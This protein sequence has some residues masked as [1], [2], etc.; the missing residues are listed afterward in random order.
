MARQNN[1]EGCYACHDRGAFLVLQQVCLRSGRSVQGHR[2]VGGG[3]GNE[4]LLG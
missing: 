4:W 1:D 2:L 3:V